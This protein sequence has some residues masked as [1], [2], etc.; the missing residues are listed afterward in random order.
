MA[1]TLLFTGFPA[2]AESPDLGSGAAPTGSDFKVFG[3]VVADYAAA[4]GDNTVFDISSGEL[5][6]ARIGLAGKIYDRVKVKAELSIDDDGDAALTD[7][8][9]EYNIGR[10]KIRIGQFKTPNALDEAA[11]S[12]FISTHER[13]AFTDAFALDRRVG[14]AILEGNDRYSYMLGVFAQNIEDDTFGGYA[15][16]GRFTYSPQLGSDDVQTHFGVSARYRNVGADQSLIRYRQRPIT[17]IPGRI[18]A[19]DR[20]AGSDLFIGFETAVTKGGFWASGEYALTVPDCDLCPDNVTFSGG[21][22]DAGFIWKGERKIKG[23]RFDRPTV[24]RGVDEGGPGAFAFVVRVDT[25]DLQGASVD[26]G[27]YN[28][29]TIGA[30]WWPTSHIR[31]GVNGFIIDADLGD[32]AGGLDAAFADAVL[33]GIREE[34]VRGVTV[35]AQVDF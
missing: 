8:Y 5:R 10:P 4:S 13:S 32:T 14:A 23:A 6:T 31:L 12:R 26:G 1:G 19:T 33:A 3:R 16:A 25:I 7:I 21:Y 34:T 20:I 22:I 28:S 24:F 9:A 30:D 27:A 15:I 29:Y 35:R 17:H 11:S 18:I 2:R